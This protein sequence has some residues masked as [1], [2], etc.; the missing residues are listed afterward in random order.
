MRVGLCRSDDISRMLPSEMA[1]IAHGSRAAR[2][3]HFARRMERTLLSYERVGW[4]EEPA[5]TRE[6]TEIR[7]AAECGPIILC[8]DTSVRPCS[9]TPG[10]PRVLSVIEAED[11]LSRFQ[12]S[13][14]IATCGP[15]GGGP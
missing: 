9:F 12:T 3:L 6:G 5:V 11:M 7:P 8:L 1:L 4:S 13:L 14:A 2:L 15:A 10:S